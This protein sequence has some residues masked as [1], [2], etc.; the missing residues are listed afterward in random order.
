MEPVIADDERHLM[1]EP[2]ENAAVVADAALIHQL[3]V[4]LLEN[5]VVHTRRGTTAWV[6]LRE[7]RGAGVAVLTVADN[8]PGLA[9]GDRARV[10]QAFQRGTAS[11]TARGSGLGLAIAQAI[12]RFHHGELRLSDNHPG[13]VVEVR[14]PLAGTHPDGSVE[15]LADAE[16]HGP[17]DRIEQPALIS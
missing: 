2:L 7:D 10:L 15:R 17:S 11:E 14:L 12:V 8:G 9:A 6:G 5:V 13:L 4:N 1:I 16:P 3:L